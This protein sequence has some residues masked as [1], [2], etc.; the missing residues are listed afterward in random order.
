MP[1]NINII[2]ILSVST[3]NHVEFDQNYIKHVD[4]FG[5]NSYL[6]DVESFNP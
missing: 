4:L 6:N 1:F 3:K 5:E 2:I